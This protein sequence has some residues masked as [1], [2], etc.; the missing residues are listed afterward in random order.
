MTAQAIDTIEA[1]IRK[2]SETQLM[3][4]VR[5]FIFSNSSIVLFLFGFMSLA[6]F[7]WL[8]RD[9]MTSHPFI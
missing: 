3:R 5:C 1:T 7:F 2:P 6:S 8:Q 9:L 4:S